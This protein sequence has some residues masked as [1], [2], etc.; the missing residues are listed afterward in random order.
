MF[1]SNNI[2][3]SKFSFFLF[4]T[5][6]LITS[7]TFSQ[8]SMLDV[9]FGNRGRVV[10]QINDTSSANDVAIKSGNNTYTKKFV[11]IK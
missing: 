4:L 5:I 11:K 8:N 9:T 2:A 10:K 3:F 6:S 1:K 7:P